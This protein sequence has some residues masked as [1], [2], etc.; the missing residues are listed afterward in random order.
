MDEENK[1]ELKALAE[2]VFSLFD[3]EYFALNENGDL[4][5]SD[6][7]M[8]LLD[9]NW[10]THYTCLCETRIDACLITN[11]DYDDF[12]RDSQVHIGDYK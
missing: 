7:E 6:E 11:F 5:L 8:F 12:W 4:F 1:K 2:K 3:Y 9:D 10:A